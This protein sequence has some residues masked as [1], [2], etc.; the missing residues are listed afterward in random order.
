MNVELARYNINSISYSDRAYQNVY[1]NGEDNRFPDYLDALYNSSVTHQSIVNDLVDYIYGKGLKAVNSSDQEKLDKFFFKKRL[2]TIIRNK[3]VQ[4]QVCIEVIKSKSNKII[5][6][7]L[8]APKQIRVSSVHRGEPEKFVYRTSWDQ[9]KYQQFKDVHYLDR[10]SRDN[11]KGLYYWY[12]SG[13]FVVPYGRPKYISGLNPI[14]LEAAIY[15]M[16]NHG[17]QNGMFPSMLIDMVTAGEDADEKALDNIVNQMAGSANAGKIGAI[18]RPAGEGNQT[19]FITPNLTGL[20]KIYENQ[21][22]TAEIG[23]LKA[24]QIPSPT[25]IS[26]LNTKSSGFSNPAEEM[27]FALKI[28]QEK[29]IEPEREEIIEI[30]EPILEGLG[31]GEVEFIG[32]EIEIEETVTEEEVQE[33]VT[34]TLSEEK[35]ELQKI[36]DGAESLEDILLN[37]WNLDSIIEVDYELEEELDRH[38]DKLNGVNNGVNLASTGRARPF[39]KSEQD[40]TKGEEQ[41]KVRYRYAGDSVGE[42]AFCADM[43]KFNK[44]YRKEDIDQMSFSNVNMGFGVKG[45]NNYNIFL[46]KGGVNCHHKWERVTFV[47]QGLEGGIDFKSPIAKANALTESEADQRGMD[48]RNNPLVATRPIDMPNQGRVTMSIIDKIRAVWQ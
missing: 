4:N 15:L 1:Q 22:Q 29:R 48:P 35:T 7:E 33:T 16:H 5:K 36:I 25:L 13:T 6:I 27:A 24:H 32:E 19:N 3:I 40:G 30:L 44:L 9:Q 38:I 34:E 10:I 20:D 39:Q 2:K 21:Y 26:G 42:R 45:A 14:E 8:L 37:G 12:D 28:L 41:Y 17:A 18:F 46:Y 43:L 31:I 23:I 11:Y 47:K